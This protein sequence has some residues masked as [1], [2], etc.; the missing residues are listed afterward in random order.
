M[1]TRSIDGE[2]TEIRVTRSLT[3]T[4]PATFDGAACAVSAVPAIA[5]TVIPTRTSERRIRR[6]VAPTV[7]PELLIAHLR[8]SWPELLSG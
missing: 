6:A 2:Y 7:V 1:T 8:P 4:M 5:A 3:W